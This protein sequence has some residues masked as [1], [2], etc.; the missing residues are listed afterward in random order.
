MIS[1]ETE[2]THVSPKTIDDDRDEPPSII[3]VTQK[4]EESCTNSPV[5]IAITK[6]SNVTDKSVGIQVNTPKPKR[7]MTLKTPCFPAADISISSQESQVST[8]QKTRKSFAEELAKKAGLTPISTK[9]D[10]STSIARRA[11]EVQTPKKTL[12][13]LSVPSSPSDDE[14]SPFLADYW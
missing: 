13:P 7:S 5:S 3:E 10:F 14:P 6:E 4:E 11:A 1:A 8:S 12:R 2:E 9:S